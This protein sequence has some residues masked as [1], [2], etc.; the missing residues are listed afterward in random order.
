MYA[1]GKIYDYMLGKLAGATGKRGRPLGKNSFRAI[2]TNE[3]YIGVYTW[4][5][6][7]YKLPAQVGRWQAEPGR[8]TH[9]GRDTAHHL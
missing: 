9:R 5:K 1:A 4:N 6:R 3:R 2:L 8:G 7:Q